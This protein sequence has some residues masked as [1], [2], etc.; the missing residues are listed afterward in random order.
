MKILLNTTYNNYNTNFTSRKPSITKE[1]L[2]RL[3]DKGYSVTEIGN[4]YGKTQSWAS[5]IIK[6]HGLKSLHNRAIDK[7][8]TCIRELI[9]NGKTIKEISE[10]FNLSRRSVYDT[11]IKV[12]GKEKLAELKTLGKQNKVQQ[13]SEK[14]KNKIINNQD[15]KDI[16][17]NVS[18]CKKEL[19]LAESQIKKE[20]RRENMSVIV[21]QALD[22]IKKGRKFTEAAR[23]IGIPG[24]TILTYTDKKALKEARIE[25]QKYKLA[26]IKDYINKGYTVR[27]I[28]KELNCSEETIYAKMG[29]KYRS[30]WKKDQMEIRM[31]NI[32]KY[33]LQGLKNKE[34]ASKLNLSEDTIQRALKNLNN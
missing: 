17:E 30:H 13:E 19:K 21:N 28:A 4:L 5:T 16:F 32:L 20:L 34:I 1:E 24:A 26:V 31:K 8:S 6:K 23:E 11:A 15:T 10:L 2:A 3:I 27:Q 25:G 18:G 33:K 9:I 12:I 14:L 29:K 7:L 22:L